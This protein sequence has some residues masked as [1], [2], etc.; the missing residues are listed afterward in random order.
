MTGSELDAALEDLAADV[1]RRVRTSAGPV[2]V[3]GNPKVGMSTITFEDEKKIRKLRD[4]SAPATAHIGT[5]KS[6]HVEPKKVPFKGT[7]NSVPAAEEPSYWERRRARKAAKRAAR[8]A[9][10]LLEEKTVLYSERHPMAFKF[11]RLLLPRIPVLCVVLPLIYFLLMNLVRGD[12]LFFIRW[13]EKSWILPQL[14]SIFSSKEAFKLWFSEYGSLTTMVI[15]LLVFSIVML[16]LSVW[17][18]IFK[19]YIRETEGVDTTEGRAYWVEG[20]NMWFNL[21]DVF[22]GLRYQRKYGQ[23]YQPERKDLKIY[24][25]TSAW[26]PPSPAAP[27]RNMLKIK[28]SKDRD[29]WI[30][31][32]GPY[33][34]VVH[35]GLFRRIT[36]IR[37]FESHNTHYESAPS[38][39]PEAKH[40]FDGRL[41]VLVRDTQTVTK[42]NVDV[43]L[44]QMKSGTIPMDDELR[45]M[46]AAERRQKREEE[47]AKR[48]AKAGS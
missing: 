43:R 18:F 8:E 1:Q 47:N 22:Y 24:L 10:P 37:E 11:S 25:N 36:G 15:L 23:P 28:I 32:R 17:R 12:Y 46:I 45:Q 44:E 35:E 7:P 14:V 26:P 20:R 5:H 3:S 33:Q 4:M 39:R 42:G 29:E 13:Y 16:Y 2:I 30:E 31:N 6:T 48:Q 19:T 38:L 41:N 40:L 27:G 34:L 9:R 21:W